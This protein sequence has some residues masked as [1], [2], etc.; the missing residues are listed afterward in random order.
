MEPRNIGPSHPPSAFDH[1]QVAADGR[2]VGQVD[3][4]ELTALL[5]RLNVD[6]FSHAAGR[7]SNIEAFAAAHAKVYH[8]AGKAAV[9]AWLK[10][11]A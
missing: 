7:Q 2:T 3:N 9:A 10:G 11:G 1:L 8:A 4:A 5:G 6:G